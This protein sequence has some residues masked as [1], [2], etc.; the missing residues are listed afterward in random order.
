MDELYA[1]VGVVTTILSAAR[2]AEKALKNVT[3]INLIAALGDA[4]CR[5]PLPRIDRGRLCRQVRAL[6]GDNS[7]Q[8][9]RNSFDQGCFYI[10]ANGK[11]KPHA[12]AE[13]AIWAATLARILHL[14]DRH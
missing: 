7:R 6:L 10:V 8:Y 4:R 14:L 11:R 2:D 3:S 5:P 13:G 9:V 1:T 12:R